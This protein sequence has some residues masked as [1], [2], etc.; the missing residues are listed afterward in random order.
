MTGMGP[1]TQAFLEDLVAH[2]D[3]ETVRHLKQVAH[4]EA[5][6]ALTTG[7]MDRHMAYGAAFHLIRA[8]LDRRDTSSGCIYLEPKE[9]EQ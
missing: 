1:K 6:D 3:L 4:Q 8:E 5:E 9:S 7:D 2:A